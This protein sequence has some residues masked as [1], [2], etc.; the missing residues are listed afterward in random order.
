MNKGQ[1]T[2]LLHGTGSLR[3]SEDDWNPSCEAK[4]QH[5]NVI[6][7]S[8]TNFLFADLANVCVDTELLVVRL[9]DITV[10]FY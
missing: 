4:D 8:S 3:C 7:D 1:N 2:R 10:R 6:L 5:I 9:L